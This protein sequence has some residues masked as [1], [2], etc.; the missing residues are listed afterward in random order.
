MAIEPITEAVEVYVSAESPE[1]PVDADEEEARQQEVVYDE[2]APNLVPALLSTD[3]G[4]AAL[5]RLENRVYREVES[6]WDSQ[7]EYRNRSKECWELFSMKLRAKTEPF[8]DCANVRLPILMENLS[9]LYMRMYIELFGDF[10]NIMTALPVGPDDRD[11]ADIVTTHDNWQLSTQLT[12]F[13]MQMERAAMFILMPGDVFAH[14]FYDVSRRRNRH[15]VL[16]VGDYVIPYVHTTTELD[17]SDCPWKAKWLNLYKH[18]LQRKREEWHDV[19]T[20]IETSKPSWDN[21]PDH[22]LADAQ[23]AQAGIVKDDE[24]RAP[25]KL[26]HYE[27]WLELPNQDKER[28]CRVIMDWATRQVMQVTILEEDDWQDVRRFEQQTA[29]LG[30]YRQQLQASSDHNGRLQ[31]LLGQGFPAPID[32]MGAP[33]QP[34]PLPPEPQW[35]D[36]DALMD[37]AFEPEP[38]RRNPI[39]MFTHQTGIL[40]PTGPLG[41]GVGQILKDINVAANTVMNQA[42]DAQTLANCWTLLMAGRGKIPADFR[43]TPGRINVLP[44]VTPK[45]LKDLLLPLQAPAPNPQMFELVRMFEGWGQSAAQAPDVMSGEAGKSGETARGIQTRLE[46][47]TKQASFMTA[48]LG[49]FV[50]Q[51]VRN[52]A[53]LNAQFL[54][55]EQVVD[56]VNHKTMSQRRLPIGRRM[57]EQNRNVVMRADLRFTSQAQRIQEADQLFN[58][59]ATAPPLA[60]NV[61][62]GQATAREM[63][64]ARGRDDLVPLLGPDVPVPT[65]PMAIPP[66]PP[67]GAA[68]PGQ[69]QPGAPPQEGP[70]LPPPQQPE[71]APPP[72]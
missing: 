27:G 8:A 36:P 64:V 55:D 57:W 19:D 46:Q 56:V 37:P 26:I 16:A 25:Y 14:S 47:A 31:G 1:V 7:E 51:L 24:Q 65:T 23:A 2:N 22:P 68:Q 58:V 15:E 40:A 42:I 18:E 50:T 69:P 28:N 17:L 30:Q 4:K 34:M 61:A 48:K 13:P 45:E 35:A 39:Q 62:L 29:E 9:R 3:K 44:N 71:P 20:L 32:E 60:H 72:Q 63:F 43:V 41:T 49:R 52:N 33:M 38:V 5:K 70:P 10:T 66:P 53:R 59:A 67:P 54:P 12:D 6:A 21:E 11:W